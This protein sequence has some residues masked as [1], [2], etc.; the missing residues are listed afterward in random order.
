MPAL[1]MWTLWKRRKNRKYGGNTTYNTMVEQVQDLVRKLVKIK[2]P[3]IKLER[4]EWIAIISQLKDYRPH[5]HYHSVTRSPPEEGNL[6]CNTDEAC[7]GNPGM[8][9]YGFCLKTTQEI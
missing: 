1:I 9:S 4:R 7:K 6:K 8:E 3:R 2:Y 5:V